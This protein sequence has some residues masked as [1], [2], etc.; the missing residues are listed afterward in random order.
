MDTATPEDPV[1]GQMTLD[2]EVRRR[3]GREPCPC[4]CGQVPVLATS[5]FVVGHDTRYAFA[6]ANLGPTKRRP[7]L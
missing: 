7:R 2:D 1:P 3:E 6:V 5:T 4:G